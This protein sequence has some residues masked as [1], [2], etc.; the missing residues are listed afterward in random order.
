[1]QH[2]AF[3]LEVTGISNLQFELNEGEIVLA[4]FPVLESAGQVFAIGFP[5]TSTQIEAVKDR[6]PADAEI[7][8]DHPE[9][10]NFRD[11]LDLRFRLLIERCAAGPLLKQALL[12]SKN[13]LTLANQ[14]MWSD[15]CFGLETL[16]LQLFGWM[17]G[18]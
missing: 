8:M 9:Q 17:T 1:M 6:L 3:W 18:G 7:L 12:S 15:L 16:H 5:M 4:L 13:C 14:A 10:F 2:P 11:W